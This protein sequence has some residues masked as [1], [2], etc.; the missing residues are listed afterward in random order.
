MESED[1]E[2]GDGA[3]KVENARLASELREAK[4]QI[5]NL[6]LQVETMKANAQR[7]ARLLDQ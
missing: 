2:E 4:T 1:S 5:R 7:A 6:E 3:I